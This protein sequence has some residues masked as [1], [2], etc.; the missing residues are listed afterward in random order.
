MMMTDDNSS[1]VRIS[2]FINQSCCQPRQVTGKCKKVKRD[3]KREKLIL[4]NL[5]TVSVK[6]TGVCKF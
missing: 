1:G 3:K 5:T 6:D 2:S 4:N